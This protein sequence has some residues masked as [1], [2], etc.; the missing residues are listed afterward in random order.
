[1]DTSTILMLGAAA[2]G[3]YFVYEM[4][5][6]P[7]AGDVA[8]NQNTSEVAANNG[9]STQAVNFYA[10]PNPAFVSSKVTTINWDAPGHSVVDVYAGNQL[11]AQ[12]NSKGSAITG[13]WIS[14]GMPFYLKSDGNVLA[15]LTMG[16]A[17]LGNMN[18]ASYLE[19]LNWSK[20]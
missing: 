8:I 3:A 14:A 2:V 16:L 6:K 10:T 9:T 1:M 11:F 12:G 13:P 19:R 20:S 7:I 17:G 4:V 18:N 15:T 5:S